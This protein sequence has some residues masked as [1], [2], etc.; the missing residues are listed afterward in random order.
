MKVSHLLFAML[1]FAPLTVEALATAVP[2]ASAGEAAPAA[3]VL[4]PGR[5]TPASIVGAPALGNAN[6]LHSPLRARKPGHVALQLS[7][8]RE[9]TS[10]ATGKLTDGRSFADGRLRGAATARRPGSIEV[11]AT[12]RAAAPL[13]AVARSATIGGPKSS[14]SRPLG[15]ATMGRTAH[16]AS[17]DG[18]QLHHKF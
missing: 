17:I 11:N 13:R 14:T 3:A 9:S 2:A 7:P 6:R 12:A 1:A 16:N 4:H 15:G 18:T 8:S 10:A 5:V